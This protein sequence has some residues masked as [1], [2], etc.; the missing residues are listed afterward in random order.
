[1]LFRSGFSGGFRHTRVTPRSEIAAFITSD[2]LSHNGAASRFFTVINREIV[3]CVGVD[4]IPE[5]LAGAEAAQV[6]REQ[7]RL[8]PR[9]AFGRAAAGAMG[10]EDDVGQVE[11]R[12]VGKR[13]LR[14]GDVDESGSQ[15]AALKGLLEG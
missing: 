9:R 8:P 2:S 5:R 1:M 15:L 11:E 3:L 14:F 7:L 10:G 6:F 4:E 13:R 12:V